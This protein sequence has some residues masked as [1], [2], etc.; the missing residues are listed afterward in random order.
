MQNKKTTDAKH[1][2]GGI[3]VHPTKLQHCQ[4]SS[5]ST[6]SIFE[7]MSQG[8]GY[9]LRI[10]DCEWNDCELLPAFFR[11]VLP[12]LML[13]DYIYVINGFYIIFTNFVLFSNGFLILNIK[14][15]Q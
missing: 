7:P 10:S 12:D 5:I 6:F 1:F 2:L 9:L 3:Y 15:I 8:N 4:Y 13:V 14:K 11:A